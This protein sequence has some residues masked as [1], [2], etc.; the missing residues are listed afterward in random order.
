MNEEIQI[1]E[2]TYG[3]RAVVAGGPSDQIVTCLLQNRV[4]ELELNDGKGWRDNDL[5]FLRRLPDLKSLTIIDLSIR[6][7]HEIHSLHNLRALN[8][9]TYCDTE[10][11]FSAFTA[12]EEC[13]L[14]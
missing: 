2:G 12:L 1:E 9:T 6:S 11:Q 5:S 7:I 13:A 8:I 10:I 4:A 3:P 14:E